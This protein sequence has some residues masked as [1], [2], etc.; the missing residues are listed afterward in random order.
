MAGSPAQGAL[1]PLAFRKELFVDMARSPFGLLSLRLAATALLLLA[2]SLGVLNVSETARAAGKVGPLAF[3][4]TKTADNRPVNP[5]GTFRYPVGEV[6][7]TF[8]V[9]DFQPGDRLTRILR[10]NGEDRGTSD[11]TCPAS[12][13]C[14]FRVAATPP[15]S[16]QEGGWQVILLVNGTQASIGGFGV[17]SGARE[18]VPSPTSSGVH[19]PGMTGHGNDNEDHENT[20]T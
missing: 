2:L 4:R 18:T 9:S 8:D 7:V 16:L 13:R 12:G 11:F 1:A 5:I 10:F 3:S 19:V 17:Q 14:A 20:N 15:D 6:W